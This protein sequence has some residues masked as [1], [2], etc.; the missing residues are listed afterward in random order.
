MTPIMNP[1]NIAWTPI[2]SVTKAEIKTKHNVIAIIIKEGPLSLPVLTMSFNRMGRIIIITIKIQPIANKNMYKA[3]R[4]LDELMIET[5]KA[6]N[7][8]AATSSPT[9]AVSAVTPTGVRNNWSSDKIRASTGN[10]YY[11]GNA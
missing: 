6:S 9:P 11:E 4:L 1:P 8:Q 3:L 2:T 10:A 7:I 5:T